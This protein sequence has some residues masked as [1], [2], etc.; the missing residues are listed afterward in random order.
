VKT[1]CFPS[2]YS[3]SLKVYPGFA[4]FA[5]FSLEENGMRRYRRGYCIRENAINPL[6][7]A[8]RQGSQI[9]SKVVRQIFTR[10]ISHWF[11]TKEFQRKGVMGRLLGMGVSA[12]LLSHRRFTI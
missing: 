1:K 9:S 8:A 5:P 4:P 2:G 7:L 12:R 11:F 3:I 6:T 10:S